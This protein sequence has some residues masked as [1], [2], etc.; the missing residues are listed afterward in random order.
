MTLC[1]ITKTLILTAQRPHDNMRRI[2]DSQIHSS[3]HFSHAHPPQN[4]EVWGLEAV[5]LSFYF[6]FLVFL[7]F[8]SLIFISISLS[9]LPW[10]VLTCAV[11]SLS[12][13]VYCWLPPGPQS[14]ALGRS[15]G[16]LCALENCGDVGIIVFVLLFPVLFF[17]FL[18]AP[19]VFSALYSF[20][21][22][23]GRKATLKQET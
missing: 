13:A 3:A 22:L 9:V 6:L 23:V 18:F 10:I 4:L 19:L 12:P 16:F 17:R 7:L 15:F 2:T 8:C 14:I 21:F 1:G 20:H 5:V 11:S